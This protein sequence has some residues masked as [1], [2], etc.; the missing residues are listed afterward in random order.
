MSPTA[1]RDLVVDRTALLEFVRPRHH[2]ILVTTR[3]DG[4]PQLSPVTMGVD[5]ADDIVISTYPD[6]A[7]ARNARRDERAS[8]CVLSDEFSGDWVQVDGSITVVDQ[9][10][11]VEELV[12]YYRCIS[13][14]HPDWE[15]YREAMRRQG[16]VLLRLRIDRWGPI[17]RGGFPP[18]LLAGTN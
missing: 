11:A 8:V 9:P 13:G 12:E 2:G 4:R 5:R 14:E 17:S 3:S 7:K 16:K 15:E 10:A 1:A 6:R 18:H